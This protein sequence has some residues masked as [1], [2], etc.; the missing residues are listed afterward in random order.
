MLDGELQWHG[1]SGHPAHNVGRFALS[2]QQMTPALPVRWPL[3]Y[4]QYVQYDVLMVHMIK[5]RD[6][7]RACWHVGPW[8]EHAVGAVCC[9][10]FAGGPF[11]CMHVHTSNEHG[12]D[13]HLCAS[14][15]AGWLAQC[16]GKM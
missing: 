15:G 6:C 3:H 5:K 4:M 8:G 14:P 9:V 11:V 16:K 2:L 7:G 10:V 1:G 12:R 13:R